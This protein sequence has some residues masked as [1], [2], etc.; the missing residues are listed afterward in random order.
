MNPARSLCHAEPQRASRVSMD[1]L[2]LGQ[3]ALQL[4]PAALSRLGSG[5]VLRLV[6]DEL[7]AWGR[8]GEADVLLAALPAEAVAD[9]SAW[10]QRHAE[11]LLAD[12]YRTHP[13][14]RAGFE[15][16]VRALYARHGADAFAAAPG[17]RPQ[18][19]LFVDDGKVVAEP[20]HGARHRYGAYCELAAAASTASAARSAEIWLDNGEAYATY[21]GMNVCRYNC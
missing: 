2:R 6:D 8:G 17:H 11:Q 9:P 19:T 13:L 7:L 5:C 20:R 12:Y 1:A 18:F 15:R 21:L 16:Q 4:D 3:L 10:L 14:S